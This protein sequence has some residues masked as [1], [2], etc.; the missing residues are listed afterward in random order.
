MLNG[1]RQAKMDFMHEII[2][3]L[4]QQQ[5]YFILQ[6]DRQMGIYIQPVFEHAEFELGSQRRIDD[7]INDNL[8]SSLC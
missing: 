4:Q 8:S 7:K 1:K 5:V 2:Q 3:N 6:L